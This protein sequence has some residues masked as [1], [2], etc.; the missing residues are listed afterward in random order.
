MDPKFE[1]FR[2][3]IH[4]STQIKSTN[5]TSY[6]P[7]FSSTLTTEDERDFYEISSFQ[8]QK[9]SNRVNSYISTPHFKDQVRLVRQKEIEGKEKER[10]L[11]EEKGRKIKEFERRKKEIERKEK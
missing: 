10:C 5:V 2:G 6:V 7:K 1:V 3:N 4:D 11:M 8:S 9:K